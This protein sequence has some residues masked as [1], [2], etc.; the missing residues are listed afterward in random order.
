MNRFFDS[1]EIPLEEEKMNVVK[2]LQ[3]IDVFPGQKTY[4]TGLFAIGMI[5][6]Q[7]FGYHTFTAE[8]WTAVGVSGGIFWKM[9][10]DR[11]KPTPKKKK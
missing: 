4:M 5:I 9:S 7:M 3:L 1:W 8:A 11:G 2:L 6:C 10:V